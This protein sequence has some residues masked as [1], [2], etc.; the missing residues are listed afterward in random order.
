MPLCV[1]CDHREAPGGNIKTYLGD[2]PIC[3]T[4]KVNCA[5][6]PVTIH[7]GAASGVIRPDMAKKIHV[8]WS[9][10]V[11]YITLPE[12][13]ERATKGL[14]AVKTMTPEEV[15]EEQE[16]QEYLERCNRVR[17]ECDFMDSFPQPKETLDRW[18]IL[19]ARTKPNWLVKAW[20]F[21]PPWWGQDELPL[22]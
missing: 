12:Y 3:I 19:Q 16:F 18:K 10:E 5:E 13:L 7:K 21:R 14:P 15:A 22:K 6:R 20:G 2:G 8:W 17:Q 9:D 1:V 4:C 11:G